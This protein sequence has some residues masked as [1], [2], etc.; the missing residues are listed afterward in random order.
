MQQPKF[1]DAIKN[2]TRKQKKEYIWEY[3]RY[4]IISVVFVLFLGGYSIYEVSQRKEMSLSIALTGGVTSME[5]M[6]EISDYLNETLLTEEQRKD[7]QVLVQSI[8]FN[9]S[10][11]DPGFEFAQK[12]VVLVAAGEIDLIV[13]DEPTFE[14]FY[15][16]GYFL[17]LNELQVDLTTFDVV[18]R[19]GLA[20]GILIEEFE[21]FEDIFP[22]EGWVLAAIVNGN[23]QDEVENFMNYLIASQK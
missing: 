11:Q 8:P 1:K 19:N 14:D 20:Y 22:M 4:H 7:Y 16:E 5:N 15:K 17:P 18:E 3:Y 2:M 23:R 10:N 12:L 6:D 9:S 13:V 21:L